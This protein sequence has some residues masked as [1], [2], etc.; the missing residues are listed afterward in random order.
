MVCM[1]HYDMRNYNVDIRLE[2]KCLASH[3]AW[4]HSRN[5][6]KP[7]VTPHASHAFSFQVITPFEA[8]REGLPWYRRHR[9]RTR[10]WQYYEV[11]K[12]SGIAQLNSKSVDKPKLLTERSSNSRFHSWTLPGQEI[13]YFPVFAWTGPRRA[14]SP[15]FLL[16]NQRIQYLMFGRTCKNVHP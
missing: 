3:Q 15:S 8:L 7:D 4:Q 14:W 12:L 1:S 2:M 9:L 16:H 13:S 6:C 11:T 10:F 5:R